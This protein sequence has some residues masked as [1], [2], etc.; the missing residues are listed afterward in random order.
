MSLSFMSLSF[1]DQK[2]VESRESALVA[3]LVR[4]PVHRKFFLIKR[5]SRDG[6]PVRSSIYLIVTLSNQVILTIERRCRVMKTCSFFTCRLYTV[7]ASTPHRRMDSTIARYILSLTRMD[8]WQLFQSL[9]R[10]RPKDLIALATL[11]CISYESITWYS[12]SEIGEFQ[13]KV[14]LVSINHDI[15]LSGSCRV[16][17]VQHLHLLDVNLQPNLFDTSKKTSTIFCIS[18]ALSFANSSSPT[19]I[20]I[21]LVFALKCATLS[22][23]ALCL[24]SM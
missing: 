8:A 14:Q 7:H 15:L 12:A 9:W 10:S 5:S 17:L 13:N 21:V 4:C 24:G 19:S 1:C 22:R 20:Q 23:S 16:G 18:C 6:S 2:T 11:L 3:C